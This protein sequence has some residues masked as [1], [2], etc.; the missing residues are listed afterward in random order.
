LRIA[1]CSSLLSFAATVP[2]AGANILS[3]GVPVQLEILSRD[4][5]V[6]RRTILKD[7]SRDHGSIEALIRYLRFRA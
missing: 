2:R 3:G 5:A 6:T 7:N 1:V 4:G